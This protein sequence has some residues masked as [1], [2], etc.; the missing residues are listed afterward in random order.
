VKFLAAIWAFIA[1]DSKVGPL[2]VALALVVAIVLR[3]SPVASLVA[4]MAFAAIVA[5]GL[6]ASVFE[7][8]V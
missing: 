6:A 5:L 3:Q 8:S 4:G 2:A 1:G 7:R